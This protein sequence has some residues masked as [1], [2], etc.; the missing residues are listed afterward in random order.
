MTVN[1]D[2][3]ANCDRCG[4]D[5][6]GYGVLY[7]LICADL[8]P[9]NQTRALIYCYTA[10]CSTAATAGLIVY[11]YV[12]AAPACSTCLTPFDYRGT[13]TAMLAVDLNGDGTARNLTFCYVNGH[14]DQ[15]LT[16]ARM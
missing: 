6:P 11:P 7:G 5:L 14:R 13:D 3:T 10:G 4:T 8:D 2:G 9:Y 16:Q 1:D 15:L 12:A